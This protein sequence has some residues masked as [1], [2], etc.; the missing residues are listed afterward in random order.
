MQV[1]CSWSMAW[2]SK[3]WTGNLSLR[4]NHLLDANTFHRRM[5]RTKLLILNCGRMTLSKPRQTSSKQYC[6]NIYWNLRK[7]LELGTRNMCH[8]YCHSSCKQ[9]LFYFTV[10]QPASC[11]YF[12]T[13]TASMIRLGCNFV[14]AIESSSTSTL[15]TPQYGQCKGRGNTD[16]AI[17]KCSSVYCTQWP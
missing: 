15:V 1:G 14:N 6:W 8:F 7:M 9:V 13:L 11:L 10:A 5:N 3:Q 12:I 17:L 16:N 4:C 2:Q